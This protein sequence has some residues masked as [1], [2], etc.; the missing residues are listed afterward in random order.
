MILRRRSW[1]IILL[2]LIVLVFEALPQP[3]VAYTTMPVRQAPLADSLLYL[4]LVVQNYCADA[5]TDDFSDPNSG[6]LV[7]DLPLVGLGYQEEE[8]EIELRLGNLFAGAPAPLSGLTSYTVEADMYRRTGS[9][10]QYALAFDFVDLKHFYIFIV[11][12]LSRNYAIGRRSGSNWVV[13]NAW[14]YSPYINPNNERNHLLV[15]RAD[16]QIMIAINNQPLTTV[17][18]KAYSGTLRVGVYAQTGDDVPAAIRFD[19]FR[20]CGASTSSF[21]RTMPSKE[22]AAIYSSSSNSAL[23]SDWNE[24]IQA[25]DT[26]RSPS[27]SK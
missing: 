20:V 22:F 26:F 17:F 11:D 19:N 27:I 2:S 12:P 18:D 13:V 21:T 8:Y 10:D 14:S 16:N 25:N 4:P 6:W 9:S 5:Y 15:T 23:I 3:L 24:L 7:A 1:L